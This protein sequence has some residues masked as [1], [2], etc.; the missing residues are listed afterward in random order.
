M[1]LVACVSVTE[2]VDRAVQDLLLKAC[3]VEVDGVMSPDWCWVS[4]V[5]IG[6]NG[7]YKI[8]EAT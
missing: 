2:V 8:I 7:S 4:E 5:V 1:A 6:C 3:A